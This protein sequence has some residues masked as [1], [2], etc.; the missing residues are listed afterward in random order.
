[1]S[2]VTEE[3]AKEKAVF[4]ALTNSFQGPVELIQKLEIKSREEE[5]SEVWITADYLQDTPAREP[6]SPSV[7]LENG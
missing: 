6:V 7:P 5:E 2:G 1:M 3:G 4:T